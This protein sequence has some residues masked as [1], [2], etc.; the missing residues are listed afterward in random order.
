[1]TKLNPEFSITLQKNLEIGTRAFTSEFLIFVNFLRK[2][3]A[4][5]PFNS[6]LIDFERV[7]LIP[8]SIVVANLCTCV[9]HSEEPAAMQKCLLNLTIQ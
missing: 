6:D 8:C 7:L 9:E 1:M 5:V 3:I 2:K 4:E